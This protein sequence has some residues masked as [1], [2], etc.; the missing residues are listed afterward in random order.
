LAPELQEFFDRLADFTKYTKCAYRNN[1]FSLHN[2]YK[3]MIQDIPDDQ[4]LNIHWTRATNRISHCHTLN[5]ETPQDLQKS[6]Q[7]E[8]SKISRESDPAHQLIRALL[9]I[10][11][12]KPY[13]ERI[14]PAN[15]LVTDDSEKI[16][17]EFRDDISLAIGSKVYAYQEGKPHQHLACFFNYLHQLECG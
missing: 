9:A 6:W 8:W 11:K 5:L 12:V 14:H 3:E 13:W 16:R 2:I 7:T 4:D 1:T 15:E 17:R 10:R